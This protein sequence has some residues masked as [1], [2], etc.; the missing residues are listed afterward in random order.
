[1]PIID[2]SPHSPQTH[3]AAFLSTRDSKA[4]KPGTLFAEQVT[5]RKSNIDTAHAFIGAA[6]GEYCLMIMRTARRRGKP[7]YLRMIACGTS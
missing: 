2:V 7:R 3:L 5:R 6:I 4:P 1:L